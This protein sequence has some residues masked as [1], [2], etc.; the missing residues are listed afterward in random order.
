MLSQQ[1]LDTQYTIGIATGVPVTFIS[2][3]NN[4]R[5]DVGGFFD[6]AQFLLN[7]ASPPSVVT[8]SYGENEEDIGTSAA[9]YV[10]I[11]LILC[12]PNDV[13]TWTANCA[14]PSSSWVLVVSPSFTRLVTVVLLALKQ[15]VAQTSWLPSHPAAHC[16]RSL[17]LFYVACFS[18]TF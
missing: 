18:K 9:K 15:L 13:N 1:D 2:A 14:M 10:L 5:D 3:G 8:T 16:K 6:L 17:S 7:E 12:S 11:A 4:I